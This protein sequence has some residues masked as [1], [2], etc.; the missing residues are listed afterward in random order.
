M[1]LEGF[2]PLASCQCVGSASRR[3]PVSGRVA[4]LR[5]DYKGFRG[6]IC[7]VCLFLST[8]CSQRFFFKHAYRRG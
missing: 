5:V 7:K 3:I 1:P 2:M 8:I 4:G 6:C